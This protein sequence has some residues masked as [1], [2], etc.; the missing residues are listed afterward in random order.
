MHLK[1]DCQVLLLQLAHQAVI[2]CSLA[3]PSLKDIVLQELL[4]NSARALRETSALYAF[5]KCP[6]DSLRINPVVLIES[7]V[8]D[9]NKC[10]LQ[11]LRHLPERHIH[12][13]GL[14]AG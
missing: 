2:K 3:R 13:V 10:M 9:S 4:G 6:R 8:L 7:L 5:D 11:V 12:A 1:A 14:L